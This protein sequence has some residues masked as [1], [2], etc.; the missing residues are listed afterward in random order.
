MGGSDNLLWVDVRSG[1][2]EVS[3]ELR[4]STSGVDQGTVTVE[5]SGVNVE[6]SW[7]FLDRHCIC[8]C[9]CLNEEVK[10]DGNRGLYIDCLLQAMMISDCYF[11]LQEFKKRKHMPQ[12]YHI[13]VASPGCV[14][15]F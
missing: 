12:N 13:V 1:L 4:D 14:F 7:L 11:L 10:H 3:P 8:N 15:D 2:S 6:S 5:K 9:V